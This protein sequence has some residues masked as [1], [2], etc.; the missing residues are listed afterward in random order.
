MSYECAY[1]H[2]LRLVLRYSIHLL[3]RNSVHTRRLPRNLCFLSSCF[4]AKGRAVKDTRKRH[5]ETRHTVYQWA[6]M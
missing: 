1:T 2:L 4:T 5:R 6:Y 3:V